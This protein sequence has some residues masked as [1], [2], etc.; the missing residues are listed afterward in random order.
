MHKVD[1]ECLKINIPAIKC[2]KRCGMKKEAVLKETFY[3][4]NKFHDSVWLSIKK[5]SWL[6]IR[7]N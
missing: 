7:K 2:F 5:R 1:A 6:K 3:V 4:N